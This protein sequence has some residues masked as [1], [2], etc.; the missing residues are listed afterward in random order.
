MKVYLHWVKQGSHE[1]VG[2][3]LDFTHRVCLADFRVGS[4]RPLPTSTLRTFDSKTSVKETGKRRNQTCP[5]RESNPVPLAQRSA[6]LTVG[7]GVRL[8]CFSRG[9]AT[10]PTERE[11]SATAE[12]SQRERIKK[13]KDSICHK[14]GAIPGPKQIQW[15]LS[16]TPVTK[17]VFSFVCW[18][19]RSNG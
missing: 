8:G 17:F 11:P 13:K 18:I 19:S 15:A 16:V 7:V 14:Q 1:G 12:N 5:P 9:L 2:A 4:E 10:S 6:I 3:I